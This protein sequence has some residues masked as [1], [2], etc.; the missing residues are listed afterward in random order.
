MIIAGNKNAAPEAEDL[1]RQAGNP[2]TVPNVPGIGPAEYRT[3]T[4]AIREVFLERLV[5]AK[6]LDRVEK[7][8]DGITM[9]TPAAVLAAACRLA[10][11]DGHEPGLGELLL[12]DVGGATTDVHSVAEGL[13]TRPEVFLRGLPEPRVKRSVEGDLGLRSSAEALLE[14]ASPAVVARLAGLSEEQVRRG[15]ERRRREPGYLPVEED[16]RRLDEALGRL[17][18]QIAVTGMGPLKIP[19]PY[20][21]TYRREGPD[22]SQRR[23]RYRRISSTGCRPG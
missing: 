17:A 7:E 2:A 22:R 16:E 19:T 3:G 20:G 6:G 18:V 1:L 11:G 5:R 14:L 4:K 9:P 12:V 13:P 8:I 15:A 10:D 23:H 21:A